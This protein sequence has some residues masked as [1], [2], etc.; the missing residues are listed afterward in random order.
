[1]DFNE[2]YQA[3][4][5]R[6]YNF[7]LNYLQNAQDAEDV[8]QEVFVRVYRKMDSFNHDAQWSTWI[9]RITVN[10]CIDFVKAK[11]RS[12]RF[13]FM[14]SLFHDETQEPRRELADFDHPGVALEHKEAVANLLAQ[15]DSL[16]ENQ[17]T[18][19]LLSKLEQRSQKEVAAIMDISEKAVESLL[20]RA[21]E[22]LQKKRK[23]RT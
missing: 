2:L 4:H 8:T 6:V 21:K 9:Y 14:V 11:K 20:H 18:A 15:I 10:C 3:H 23:P 1:M 7:C 22:N 17:K 16:P 19:L 13:G 5:R 12:K